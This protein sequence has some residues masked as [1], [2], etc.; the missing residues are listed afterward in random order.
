MS[1]PTLGLPDLTKPFELFA[2]ERLNIAYGVLAE[3]LGNQRRT[4]AYFSKQLDNV[5]Q[6]WPGCLKAV[7]ATVLLIQ[8][9]Q[10]LTLG[11]RIVVY[12]PYAMAAVLEQKGDIGYPDPGKGINA[13]KTIPLGLKFKDTTASGLE[14]YKQNSSKDPL[15]LVDTKLSMSQQ[16]ALVAKKVNGILGCIGK[17]TAS[18]S[19]EVILLPYFALVK[20]RLEYCVQFW[21]PQIKHNKKLLE[22]I[23]RRVKKMMKGLEHLL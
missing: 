21:A 20:P 22:K 4:V 10:K 19:R 13:D 1:T 17:S 5:A 11:R 16:C 7:A 14:K 12:V 8:E 18:R 9:T 2:Y 15:V 6:G 3:C 23:Q